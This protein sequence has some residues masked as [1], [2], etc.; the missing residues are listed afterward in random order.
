MFNNVMSARGLTEGGDN[1]AVGHLRFIERLRGFTTDRT[2]QHYVINPEGVVAERR[3]YDPNI[4]LPNG[5]AS[6]ELQANTILGYLQVYITTGKKEFLDRAIS[7][8]NTYLTVFYRGQSIPKDGGIIKANFAVN[9]KEPVLSHY[10]INV[11]DPKSSGYKGVPIV[12]TN[13]VAQIPHGAPFWGEYLDI[14]AFAHRGHMETESIDGRVKDI[15]NV[16]DWSVVYQ[17]YRILDPVNITDSRAWVN[18]NGYLNNTEG[19][20]LDWGA[21]FQTPKAISRIVTADGNIINNS[22]RQILETGKEIFDRGLI[23]FEDTTLN[24]VYLVNY[25]VKLPAGNGGRVINR[26]EPVD[27]VPLFVPVE[28]TTGAAKTKHYLNNIEVEQWVA[29]I[30][31]TLNLYTEN[32]YLDLYQ[33]V[34]TNIQSYVG[35]TD[36]DKFFT[37]STEIGVPFLAGRTIDGIKPVGSRIRYDRD[38]DGYISIST[39]NPFELFVEQQLMW[40]RINAQSI[41]TTTYGGRATN[42]TSVRFILD[43][44]LG[45]DK[46]SE[47]GDILYTY[48]LPP[49]IGPVKKVDIP[50][51]KLRR[52]LRLDGTPY[53]LADYETSV[54][55]GNAVLKLQYD[56]NI[57]QKHVGF[58]NAITFPNLGGEVKLSFKSIGRDSFPVQKILYRS[59]GVTQ[60]ELTD[61]DGWY[62]HW[63]IPNTSN[64]W[65]NFNLLVDGL[66]LSDNQP[67]HGGTVPRPKDPIYNLVEELRI[68]L[69]DGTQS[70]VKFD[71]YCLNDTPDYFNG[72]DGYTFNYRITMKGNFAARLMIGDCYTSKQRLDEL[73]YV[74]GVLPFVG[75]TERGIKRAP[76]LRGMPYTSY[77]NPFIYVVQDGK[78]QELSNMVDFLAD[79]Q[80]AYYNKFMIYGP[81]MSAFSWSRWDNTLYTPGDTWT[82]FHWGDQTP[83]VSYQS[84]SFYNAAKAHYELTIRKKNIPLRLGIYLNRWVSYLEDFLLSHTGTLPN[85]FPDDNLPSV[86]GNE[87]TSFGDIGNWLSGLCFCYLSGVST[88]ASTLGIEIVMNQL[89]SNYQITED[90]DAIMNG[91]WTEDLGEGFGANNTGHYYGIDIGSL[92][93]GLSLYESFRSLYPGQSIYEAKDGKYTDIIN[94]DLSHILTEDIKEKQIILD[95]NGDRI[96]LEGY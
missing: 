17:H 29:E 5:Y 58:I 81:V 62:W 66:V 7:Y 19:Y 24:G 53:L 49:A 8:F 92:L 70:D 3:H 10:P 89:N 87:P 72:V 6:T 32:K 86:N 4:Y 36:N 73:P 30:A 54:V 79:A 23:Y 20:T 47:S 57:D 42:S 96:I 59:S 12:I 34:M 77:Q 60:V 37:Q 63:S 50:F 84:R 35:I 22:T 55:S 28:G 38:I 82:M 51:S 69:N 18:W 68:R 71:F 83:D 93:R 21:T 90:P 13:G 91:S 48:E 27:T 26:N 1:L 56:D 14:A 11:N 39:Y 88:S 45:I 33:S 52:K 80:E 67:N 94:P 15:K 75:P 61:N 44:N 74:P 64:R 25:A 85:V 76:A 2:Q 41:L 31:Y 78:E 40:S 16:I 9:G 65:S 95:E 46:V 43:V